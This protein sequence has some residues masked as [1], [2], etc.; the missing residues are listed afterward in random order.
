MFT[1]PD[2]V[3]VTTVKQSLGHVQ[4][5]QGCCCSRGWT[6]MGQILHCWQLA[7]VISILQYVEIQESS[8]PRCSLQLGLMEPDQ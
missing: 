4:K 5:G 1:L 7:R 3:I 6:N 2:G 8:C